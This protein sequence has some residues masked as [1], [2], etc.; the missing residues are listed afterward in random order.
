MAPEVVIAFAAIGFSAL[1]FVAAQLTTR[2]T[3]DKDY[4]DSLEKRIV[5]LEQ[6]LHN[7][8]MTSTRYQEEQI[9]LLRKLAG[10]PGVQ[11]IDGVTSFD[12]AAGG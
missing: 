6:D 9:F 4:V 2:R 8:L 5:K 7:C 1:T 3:A 10:L 12:E 11:G